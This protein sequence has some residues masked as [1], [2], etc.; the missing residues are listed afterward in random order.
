MNN[1]SDLS[2]L[3]LFL[4]EG[5][6][7]YFDVVGFDKKPITDPLYVSRL[8]IYLEE[9]KHIPE[10]YKSCRYKA[11][12]FMEPRIVDDYPIRD[13]LVSLSLKRRRWD[14]MVDEKWIKV[15]RSWEDFIAQGTRLSKEFAAFL[16]EGNR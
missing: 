10:A 14:V 4:P 3:N 1:M 13:N 5:L 8:T 12:G 9:K 7:D 15:N 6:L 2:L 11:S 16:K